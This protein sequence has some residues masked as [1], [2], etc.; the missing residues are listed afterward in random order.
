M[1]YEIEVIERSKKGI[2]FHLFTMEG[3]SWNQLSGAC[4]LTME[5]STF[6]V[7]CERLGIDYDIAE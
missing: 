2:K 3:E 5:L 4:G 6:D 7:F 1:I